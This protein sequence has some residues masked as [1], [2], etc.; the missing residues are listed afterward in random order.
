MDSANHKEHWER[1]WKYFSL[2]ADQRL[3]TFNFYIVLST[4]IVGALL[5]HLKNAQDACPLVGGGVFLFLLSFVFWKL[6]RR[7]VALI[8]HAEEA[9]KLIETM[10]SS[11]GIP[12][13][14]RLFSMEQAR[15]DQL[16]ATGARGLWKAMAWLLGPW[17]YSHCFNVVFVVVSV[18]G[19][20]IAVLG[21]VVGTR[22]AAVQQPPAYQPFF[23]GGKGDEPLRANTRQL[24]QCR[25]DLTAKSN[26]FPVL[27]RSSGQRF[28]T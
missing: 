21:A 22:T 11:D 13:E 3:K 5:S 14:L 1:A 7:N 19:V 25:L 10:N 12:M 28:L 4:V 16:R 23:L 18:A 2:H 6:D 8:K 17:S 27:C 26:R 9:I 24:L 15:T 20:L